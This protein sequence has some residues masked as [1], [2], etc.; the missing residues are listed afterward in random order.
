MDYNVLNE[1][2]N[3]QIQAGRAYKEKLL[4]MTKNPMQVQEIFLMKII[5]DNKDTEYGR[6]YGF[7]SIRSIRDY[8]EKVPLS[9]Y[10]DYAPYIERMTEKCERGLICVYD[11]VYYNKSSGTIGVPKRIPYSEEGRKKFSLAIRLL[12][13]AAIQEAVGEK[14]YGGRCINLVQCGDSLKK[15]PDG[16]YWG[17]ISEVSLM[18]YRDWWSSFFTSPV[19]ASYAAP[20]TNTRYLHARFALE[21]PDAGNMLF[22]YAGFALEMCRYIEKNWEMIV[23]DIER[24][25]INHSVE[26]PDATREALLEKLTPMPERAAVLKSIFEQGFEEPF[27][28]KVWPK[29]GYVYGGATG[30]FKDYARKFQERYL[31]YDIPFYRRGVG[32][33][34]GAFSQ[35]VEVNTCDSVLLPDSVFYE[36]IP[37]DEENPDMVHLLT[38][39]QMEVGKKYELVITNLSGFYRYRM[40]DVFLVTGMLNKT[41]LIEYQYRSDRTVD[42]MGE[43]TTEAAVRAAAEETATE[44]G[45]DLVDCT[46]YPDTDAPCYVYLLEA[47]NIPEGLSEET[48]RECLEANLVK[49][50]PSMGD[51]LK[52]GFCKPVKLHFLQP[53]TFLLYGEMLR[54]KGLST[55]QMKPVTV[56]TNEREKRFFFGLK[57]DY[58]DL[59]DGNV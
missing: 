43:K 18:E 44:C 10:D 53:E 38:M 37:A 33:S 3:K 24:G 52:R 34:E 27:I 5:S 8:Q 41:P 4:E 20:G 39:D 2:R 6:K 32:A 48:I 13:K 30:G 45:F 11:P 29:M 31:G 58:K 42:L 57:V 56:I 17:P 26:I 28:P 47:E 19:E 25:R 15:L 7:D 55:A 49:V 16:L 54:I 46:M 12:E 14:Y 23:E 40:K 22:T 35:A 51:K 59:I 21:D 1:R 36:F 50:N 9:T